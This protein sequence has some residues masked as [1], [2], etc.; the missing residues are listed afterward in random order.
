MTAAPIMTAP[1]TSIASTRNNNP[2]ATSGSRNG[3][4]SLNRGIEYLRNAFFGF[5]SPVGGG[6]GA[7]GRGGGAGLPQYTIQT[8]N[9]TSNGSSNGSHDQPLRRFAT[10]EHEHFLHSVDPHRHR[11]ESS[12]DWTLSITTSTPIEAPSLDKVEDI[13]TTTTASSA[14]TTTT[15]TTKPPHLRN[16]FRLPPTTFAPT[17]P[18][19]LLH[20][21]PPVSHTVQASPIASAVSITTTPITSQPS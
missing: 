19:D 14:T 15:T 10:P 1:L 17:P 13:P 18:P 20:H 16:G 3:G 2:T 6:G 8:H 4:G 5:G 7:F 9:D 21:P 11:P 12:T